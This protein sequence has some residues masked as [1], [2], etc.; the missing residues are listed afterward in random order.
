MS[1]QHGKGSILL[2]LAVVVFVIL[3][4]IVITTPGKIWSSE[5]KATKICRDNMLSLYEAHSYYFKIKHTHA[6]DMTN[7]VLAIQSDS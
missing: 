1:D 2:K 7:L 4:I 6:P 3:L 5:E